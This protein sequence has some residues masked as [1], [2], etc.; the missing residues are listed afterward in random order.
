LRIPERIPPL[1]GL[2][3]E[4]WKEQYPD[5]RF[6]QF[7]AALPSLLGLPEDPFYVED[8]FTIAMVVKLL[9]ENR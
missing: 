1:L 7:V 2:L 6:F 3:E 4:L 5:L 9:Q 8:D